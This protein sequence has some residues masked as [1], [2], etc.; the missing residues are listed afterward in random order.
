[1][2]PFD[3]GRVVLDKKYKLIYNPL[4]YLYYSPIDCFKDP[5]WLELVQLNKEGK[6]DPVFKKTILFSQERP[7]FE[8]FDTE[9][10]PGEFNNLIGNPAYEQVEYRLKKE[11]NEWMIVYRDVIPTPFR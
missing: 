11:L 4:Y 10:D 3:L 7:M 2:N 9:A 6:I 5:F 1:M 8:L